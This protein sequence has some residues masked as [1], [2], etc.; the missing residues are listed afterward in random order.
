MQMEI[1]TGVMKRVLATCVLALLAVAGPARPQSPA[2]APSPAQPQPPERSAT[3]REAP[4]NL[5]L[6]NPAR[7]VSREEPPA[8]KQLPSLGST[9]QAPARP[10]EAPSPEKVFPKDTNPGR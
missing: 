6:D 4:L 10:F 3:P 2:P 7:F 1:G 5:R 8:D 9:P